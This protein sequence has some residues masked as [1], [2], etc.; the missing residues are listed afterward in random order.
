MTDNPHLRRI[1]LQLD[2]PRRRPN[3]PPLLH[4]RSLRALLRYTPA[5]FPFPQTTHL[6][7]PIPL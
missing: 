2:A 6:T 7:N 1:P 3:L 5:P 4:D